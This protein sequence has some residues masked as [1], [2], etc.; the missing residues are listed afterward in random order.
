MDTVRRPD[1]TPQDSDRE[2]LTEAAALVAGL[3]ADPFDHAARAE[4]R[5]WLRRRETSARP[6]GATCPCGEG[7]NPLHAL[8]DCG[9]RP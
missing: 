4:A 9:S 3:L 1:R 7:A 8:L 5:L 2:E 6:R